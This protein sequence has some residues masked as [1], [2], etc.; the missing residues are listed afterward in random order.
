MTKD[1]APTNVVVHEMGHCL[2]LHHTHETKFGTETLSNCTYAGDLICDTPPD[3]NIRVAYPSGAE[4]T[5]VDSNCNYTKDDGYNPDTKNMMSYTSL[6]C[7]DHFTLQQQIRMR[8]AILG[9]PILQSAINCSCS[10]NTLIGKSEICNTETNTYLI[11]C[12]N[13]IFSISNNLQII[14]QNGNSV[15][16]KPVSSNTFAQA[17][18]DYT[19]GSVTT[20]K[21]IWIGLPIVNLTLTTDSNYVYLDL[22]DGTIDIDK[23]NITHI[24]WEVISSS[25]NPTMAPAINSFS[26]VC[27]GNSTNWTMDIKIKITNNCGTF[28]LYRT[29]TPAVSSG[30]S[31][32]IMAENGSGQ[33]S[34]VNN[35]IFPCS[36]TSQGN[37]TLSNTSKSSYLIVKPEDI[38]Y[39]NLYSVQGVK[40]LSYKSKNLFDTR[41]LPKGAYFVKA[42]IKNKLINLKLILK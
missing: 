23:Q 11:P 25:G 8:D 21:W 42:K 1:F 34:I 30:C 17:Y 40:I 19:I 24:E 12:G 29:V 15:T 35:I 10:D 14:T 37:S 31:D 5:Y 9:K 20:R 36:S 13:A 32:F 27:K 2:N 33:Y 22:L 7:M 3:S 6:E 41:N 39:A 4:I 18:I 26:N 16:V 28:N 38:E